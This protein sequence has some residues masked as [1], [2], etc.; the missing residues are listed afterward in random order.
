MLA[1]RVNLNKQIVW[2]IK[3]NKK[4][5]YKQKNKNNLNLIK[6]GEPENPQP[7]LKRLS[8]DSEGMPTNHNYLN[9]KLILIKF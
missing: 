1:C 2:E 4:Y 7:E 5:N 9:L 8:K 6:A 3:T